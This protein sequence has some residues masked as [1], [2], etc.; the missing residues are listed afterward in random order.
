MATKRY[1]LT[2]VRRFRERLRTM[3]GE[4]LAA[5]LRAMVAVEEAIREIRDR[6]TVTHEA[7]TRAA[8]RIFDVGDEGP[9]AM[10]RIQRE[11]AEIEQRRLAIRELNQAL[12]GRESEL[13]RAR[14]RVGEA[15]VALTE[16]A[17]AVEVLEKHHERWCQEQRR[18]RLKAEARRR[19][20]LSTALWVRRQLGRQL[21]QQ[22]GQQVESGLGEQVAKEAS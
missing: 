19:G 6:L 12:E 1:P 13:A 4:R 7:Q 15:R 2:A 3:A 8:A 5:S 9:V 11:H 18:L 10:R 14:E 17:R 22:V 20:E 16:A 21:G